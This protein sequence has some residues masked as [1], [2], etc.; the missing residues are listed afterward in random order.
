MNKIEQK[1]KK[2]LSYSILFLKDKDKLV[3]LKNYKLNL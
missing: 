3:N 1:Q 2:L